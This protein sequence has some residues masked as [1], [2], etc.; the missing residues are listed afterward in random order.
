[1]K[2]LFL[3]LGL[4][5]FVSPFFASAQTSCTSDTAG[6]SR[7]QLEQELAAC[8]RE[9]AEWT[10]TLNKTKQESA[11]FSRDVA[12]LTA[13]INAA[14]ANI[15]AKNNKISTLSKDIAIKQGQIATLDG[16]ID[17]GKRAI[18]EILR[19]TNDISSSSLVE[20]VLSDK[21]LSEFF[22]DLD[23]Y[24][25]TEEAFENL[26]AELRTN[27]ALTEAE[28]AAL[29][30]KRQEEASAKAALEAAKKEVE[31]ANKEKKTLLA[32]SQT[33]E[34]TYAQVLADKQ[35]KAA[36]IKSVLFPLLDSNTGPIQ[37]GTALQYAKAA[38][39][40]TG[41]R[42]AFI[43]GIFATESGKATD[44]TFG[45]FV[46]NCLLTNNPN[47]GDGKGKN[48]GSYIAQ[49]MKGS[50]DA[51]PFVE[52]VNK[53]GLDPYSQPV[54]CPQTGGYGGGMGPAQFIASTWKL[55]EPRL[56]KSLGKSNP[57]PWNPADA[58]TAAGFYLADIGAANGSYEAERKAAHRYNGTSAP[59]GTSIYHY[60][61]AVMNRATEIQKDIE[62][63]DSL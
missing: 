22:V 30:K 21:A 61:N 37:F 25:S 19:K 8:D 1:M 59:C 47:K 17:K 24:A 36:K 14:Q 48:S 2:K 18:A 39:A 45:K 20:A 50:R 33:N 27:K 58:F 16:R 44:G 28:K 15:K 60:C 26:F 41:V 57:N 62:L 42:A 9:I 56:I 29:D 63:I 13:K 31:I 32:V 49:V 5:F 34:K 43:L 7:S 55:I 54:S 23:T 12:A 51:D 52:I 11:S 6:K 53:L 35:A 3:F 4:F 46:G 40:R 38:E 10:A